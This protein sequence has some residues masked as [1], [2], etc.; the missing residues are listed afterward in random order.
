MPNIPTPP[1][2]HIPPWLDEAAPGAADA[3]RIISTDPNLSEPQRERLQRLVSDSTRRA[4]RELRVRRQKSKKQLSDDELWQAQHEIMWEAYRAPDLPPVGLPEIH[5]TKAG[6]AKIGK[7]AVKLGNDIWKLNDVQLTG[8]WALYRRKFP[9]DDLVQSLPDNLQAIAKMLDRIGKFLGLAARPYKPYGPVD[10]VG[11]PGDSEAL[12]TVVI[13]RI[14]KTCEKH[15]GASLYT[16]V[17]TFANASL[18]RQDI[19]NM[20][21]RQSLQPDKARQSRRPSKSKTLL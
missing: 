11:Q 10:P 8:M 19:T 18:N 21:V 12:K 5:R 16:T 13:R 15:F 6:L 7:S 1:W 14:A 4:W 17:A 9:A 3:A 2:L 20:T